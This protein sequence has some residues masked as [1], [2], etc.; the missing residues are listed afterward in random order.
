[1]ATEQSKSPFCLKH[2]RACWKNYTVSLLSLL[3]FNQI[4]FLEPLLT[5]Y[6]LFLVPFTVPCNFLHLS[7]SSLKWCCEKRTLHYLEFSGASR[8]QLLHLYLLSCCL[9][10]YSAC[11]DCVCCFPGIIHCPCLYSIPDR[12]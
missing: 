11:C 10:Y 4:L 7:P 9:P 1:M 3:I 2:M 8:A 5:G 6:S 12:C